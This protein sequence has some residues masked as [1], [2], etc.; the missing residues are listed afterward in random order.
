MLLWWAFIRIN[1]MNPWNPERRVASSWIRPAS[2]G[3][4]GD[5]WGTLGH[6]KMRLVSLDVTDSLIVWGF[7]CHSNIFHSFE[8][9][10]IAGDD[11]KFW[12]N[13]ALMAIEQWGFF[14]MPHLLWHRVSVCNGHLWG[15]TP[16]SEPQAVEM[17]H[18]PILTTSISHDWDLNTQ[19]SACVVNVLTN[20]ATTAAQIS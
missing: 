2:M 17:S 12:P 8:D 5:S 3:R 10:T 1:P 13:S 7:T 6:W 14:S 19:P 4:V 20:C 16:V 11:F 18:V 15:L 9:V